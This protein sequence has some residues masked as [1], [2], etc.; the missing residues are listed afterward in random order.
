MHWRTGWHGNSRAGRGVG[1]E[2]ATAVRGMGFGAPNAL[3]EH[4]GERGADRRL[5]ARV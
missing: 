2:N 4:R 1:E 3:R 5:R